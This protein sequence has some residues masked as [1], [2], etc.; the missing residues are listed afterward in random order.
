M[1]LREFALLFF[2]VLP[3]GCQ[4]YRDVE[5]LEKDRGYLLISKCRKYAHY[6]KENG[7]S[8][9]GPFERQLAGGETEC[10]E[11]RIEYV[12][13]HPVHGPLV[14]LTTTYK[15]FV[16]QGYDG[17]KQNRM[18]GDFDHIETPLGSF[19]TPDGRAIDD[20]RGFKAAD[21]AETKKNFQEQYPKI[22]KLI[23][24]KF[25]EFAEI[26]DEPKPQP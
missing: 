5:P 16:V 14:R 26:P 18:D 15:G 2:L 1:S 7:F 9:E 8:V 3:A 6:E 22:K 20:Q 13:N 12:R 21:I 4:T 10:Y 19:D 24:Y 25:G 17:W 11:G 23:L